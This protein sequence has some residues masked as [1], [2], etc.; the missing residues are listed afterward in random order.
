MA[1]H[2]RIRDWAAATYTECTGLPSVTEQHVPAWDVVDPNTGEVEEARLD[3]ATS[4]AVTGGSLYLDVVVKCAF[5]E[6]PALLRRRAR[7]AGCAACDA[8]GEKHRR[9]PAAG[10]SLI[11]LALEA[12][13]RPSD[14]TAAFVRACGAAYVRNHMTDDGGDSPPNPS[15]RLWQELSVRLQIGN[16]ELLLSALGR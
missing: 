7:R 5:S 14:E 9:Y 4:D 2:N 1:H 3:V 10:A 13:G 16:A 12:G 6:D 11:P 15:W 8:A